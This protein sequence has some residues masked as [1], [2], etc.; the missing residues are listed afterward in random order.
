L[1]T[2]ARPRGFRRWTGI[3]ARFWQVSPVSACAGILLLCIILIAV[4]APVIAPYDP[5]AGDYSAI[6]QGPSSSHWMGT[7]DLG[8]DVFSRIVYGARTSLIV[9]FGAVLVGD[10]IGLISGI[11]TGYVG[12]RTDLISQRLLEVL[13]AFPGLILATLFVVALGAGIGTVIIAIAVTRIPAMNRVVRAVT[14]S[15]RDMDFVNASRVSGASTL[16]ILWRHIAPQ[17]VAPF[18]V[19][20]SLHLGIAITAEAALSFL[21]IGIPPPRPSWGTMIGGSIGSQFSPPW[22][23]AVFPGL[24]IAITVFAVN[25]SGDGLRDL[26]DPQLRGRIEQN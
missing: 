17:T 9:G 21:G 7:D 1:P 12:G 25:V 13:L 6:R 5:L 20:A 18:L 3:L 23:L 8:R 10:T 2:R 14:I 4:F 24:A 22:W 15:V 11:I 26:L 19:V 16:R